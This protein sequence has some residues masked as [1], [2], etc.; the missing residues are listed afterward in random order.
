MGRF[1]THLPGESVQKDLKELLTILTVSHIPLGS[2]SREH[3][4]TLKGD[5]ATMF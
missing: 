2:T 5:E 4:L 3:I 1:D